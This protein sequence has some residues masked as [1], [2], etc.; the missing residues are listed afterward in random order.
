MIRSFAYA[1]ATHRR[2]LGRH[3]APGWEPAARAAF[4][5]GYLGTVDPSL[6]PSSPVATRRLLELF[7]LE[8]KYGEYKMARKGTQSWGDP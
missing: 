4:L 1:A 5:D 2:S 6:L 3:L 7:E 8:K